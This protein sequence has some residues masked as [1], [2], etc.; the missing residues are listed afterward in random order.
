MNVEEEDVDRFLIALEEF[1][2]FGWVCGAAADCHRFEW[3]EEALEALD[4]Q[5]LIVD[6]V[7]AEWGGIHWHIY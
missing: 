3:G 1:E 2:S 4:G 7:G 5:G 6:E